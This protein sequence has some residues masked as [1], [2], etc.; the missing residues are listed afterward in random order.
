MR[1]LSLESLMDTTPLNP[2]I[3]LNDDSR[4]D[5]FLEKWGY[6]GKYSLDIETYGANES[7]GLNP[8]LDRIRLI[9]V[10]L[11][12][13]DILVIDLFKKIPEKFLETLEERLLNGSPIGQNIFF[14]L[15]F[16]KTQ[17]GF[18]CLHPIDT[19]ILSIL[20][21]CGIKW[22]NN[23]RVKHSLKAIVK[24]LFGEDI[25]KQQ[26]TSDFGSLSLSN[27]QINYA[28]DDVIWTWRSYQKLI[29]NLRD[30]DHIP[31][32]Q[33][34][35]VYYDSLLDIARIECDS[36]PAFVEI[37][38]T[39][40]PIDVPY[41]QQVITQ[42]KDALEDLY[43][44][45][46]AKIKE[47]YSAESVA[48]CTAIY[49]YYGIK[50]LIEDRQ[51]RDLDPEDK[52][53]I[54]EPKQLSLFEE[55]KD[56]LKLEIPKGYVLTS[57]SPVLFEYYIEYQ[58][59]DLL[60]ISLARSM[61]KSI[62]ALEALVKSAIQNNGRARGWYSPLGNTGSGRSTCNSG[63]KKA[64]LK[65]LNLQN[66]PNDLEHPLIDKY[67]LPSIRSI[68]AA[69]EAKGM[70]L[71][72]LS[73]S[74]L[75]LAAKHSGDRNLVDILEL[76]DPH[77]LV[78]QKIME[79]A[80]ITEDENGNPITV[81]YC[82]KNKKTSLVS[83][84]RHIAKISTYTQFN[85]GKAFTFRKSLQKSFIDVSIEDCKLAQNALSEIFKDYTEYA[86]EL[87][88]NAYYCMVQL[89]SNKYVRYKTHDGRL[90]HVEAY[91]K[92]WQGKKY[93]KIKLGEITSSMLISPEA[94]IMKNALAD[95]YQY[96]IQN[97]HLPI[98]LCSFTHDDISGED[99]TKD[100]RF[101]RF[102]YDTIGRYFNEYLGDIKSTIEIGSDKFKTCLINNYS[103]K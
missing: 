75:R 40:Q 34:G 4:V 8:F 86:Q 73:A 22:A 1:Q 41:A 16:I 89:G 38:L 82:I 39:G 90:F 52:K 45:V 18:E 88:E 47:T 7:D 53:E 23:Q 33:E 69:K 58:E 62:D 49:Q 71:V 51:V 87:K 67:K 80:G 15:S 44:P 100:K 6:C 17:F 5:F 61:K 91:P 25:D 85:D 95:I 36:I 54:V 20:E 32:L 102:V 103:E 99:Y 59:E 24:R 11:G 2:K 98:S 77:A 84:Y 13:G 21:S 81:E 12:S 60:R 50:L 31:C 19:M 48:L 27:S 76:K 78:T 93:D 26:Q 66:L 83:Y 92:E 97:R 70:F 46:Y 55:S 79:L 42:Y 64:S 14:D 68:I 28:C 43:S 94:L 72:D 35:K 29:Q 65:A 101:A 96:L 74:H 57:A 37:F 30:L 63:G 3:I 56:L 9:Q 10:Y